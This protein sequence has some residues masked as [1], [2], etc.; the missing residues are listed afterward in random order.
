MNGLSGNE[1]LEGQPRHRVL[2]HILPRLRL[3]GSKDERPGNE[4]RV[5]GTLPKILVLDFSH[6]VI[7]RVIH[8]LRDL[9]WILGV[10]LSAQYCMP[11]AEAAGQ[12]GNMVELSNLSQPSLGIRE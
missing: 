9:T 2:R 6:L 11:L 5:R 4:E 3:G 10:A 1:G 12:L 7:Y 8:L